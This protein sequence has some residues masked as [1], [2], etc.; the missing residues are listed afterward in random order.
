MVKLASLLL[1]LLLLSCAQEG[2]EDSQPLPT[3]DIHFFR[4]KVQPV[5]AAGCAFMACHGNDERPLSIYAAKRYRKDIPWDDYELPLTPEELQDNLT[6][7]SGFVRP[8]NYLAQKPLD[9]QAGGF[10]H[11]AKGLFGAQDVFSRAD[12]P[13]YQILLQFA[14]GQRAA[15]DCQPTEET[16]L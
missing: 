14:E 15:E 13:G 10:Y 11:Q 16:G 2:I 5:L 6:I 7:A 4:C 12:N 1:P 8:H 9:S 3:L